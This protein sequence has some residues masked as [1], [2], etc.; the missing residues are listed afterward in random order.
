[1]F[2]IPFDFTQDSK[3]SSATVGMF[4]P[5]VLNLAVSLLVMVLHTHGKRPTFAYLLPLSPSKLEFQVFGGFKKLLSVAKF[6]IIFH[7]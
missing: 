3:L 5:Y 4:G 2:S 6:Q 7:I 1:M